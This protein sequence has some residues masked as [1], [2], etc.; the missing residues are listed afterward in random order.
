MSTNLK[1]PG[2]EL[3]DVI[4]TGNNTILYRAHAIA[5]QQPVVLK[6]LRAEYPTL[7]QIARLNHEYKV[8][9]RLDLEGIVRVYELISLQNRLVLVCEDFGGLS[10]K[11]WL[12]GEGSRQRR[13]AVGEFLQIG[14]QLAR[15]LESLQQQQIIHKDIKPANIIINPQTNVVKLADFSIASRLSQET[16]QLENSTQLEGTLLYMSPEQTGRMNRAVDYR[17][18]FYS[19]GVTFYELLTGQVPFQS[20]D[21][22][23]LVHCHIAKEPLPIHELNPEVPEGVAAIVTKLMAKNAEDRYQS[24]AGLLA[25]LQTCLTQWQQQGTIDP[26]IPGRLD[27]LSQLTIPPTLYGREPEQA[28]LLAAF[29]RIAGNQKSDRRHQANTSPSPPA[30]RHSPPSAASPSEL[31]LISGYAGIGKSSLVN[32]F[33]Q[34]VTQQGGYFVTGKFDQFKRHIPYAPFIQTFGALMRQLLLEREEQLEHWCDRLQQA[35]GE[36]GQVIIDVIPELELVIGE[37]PAVIHLSPT[38]AQ[39]RFN[40]V[41]RNFIQVFAQPES[42]LVIFLDDLQW[43]DSASLKL[44]YLLMTAP[45]NH[46]LLFIGAY[47]NHEM[48]PS[49]PLLPT[50]QE[51]QQAGTRVNQIELHPLSLESVTQLIAETLNEASDHILPLAQCLYQQ[52]GG[53][54]F[55]LTQLLYTLSQET[56]LT[57]DFEA[58]R[59]Q[60]NLEQVETTGMLEQDMVAL[61]EHRIQK[62]PK[63]TQNVFKFA[64]CIG[65]KFSLETLSLVCEQSSIAITNALH[66]A[67]KAELLL[68]LRRQEQDPPGEPGVLPTK[69]RAFKS[70]PTYQFGHEQIYQAAYSL[71]ADSE[72]K[73]VH[74]KVGQLLLRDRSAPE[75]E[76]NIFEIVNQL[77]AGCDLLTDPVKRAQ[78]AHLNLTA[79]RR[80]KAAMAYQAAANYLQI[81]RSLLPDTAWETTYDLT[82]GLH[83]EAVDSEFAATHFDRAEELAAIVL[84][85]AKDH[86]DKAK[87]YLVLV[88]LYGVTQQAARSIQTAFAAMEELQVAIVALPPSVPGKPARVALSLP[89]LEAIDTLPQMSNPI[90]LAAM[91]I[92]VAL[93]PVAYL[94]DF[95]VLY[96]VVL[97]EINLSLEYGHCPQSASAYV[98][99]GAILSGAIGD[100]AQGYHAGQ[101]GLKLL[102]QYNTKEIKCIVHNLIAA[103][104]NHWQEH[105]R[106]TLPRLMLA[107]E[108]ALDIGDYA[109]AGNTAMEYCHQCFWVEESLETVGCDQQKI[110]DLLL[111][112]KQDATLAYA[113]V[114][115][116]LVQNLQGQ[117]TD[118][119]QLV[120]E[121]YNELETLPI[122][123]ETSNRGALCCLYLAKTVLH[124]LLGNFG[125]AVENAALAAEH[126]QVVV[127]SMLVSGHNFYSSL[128]LLA[129]YSEVAPALQE[130]YLQQVATHQEQLRHWATHAPM[131]FQHKCDLIEAEQCRIGGQH[132]Q[133]MGLYD[134][135]I[136]GAMENGYSQEAAIANELAGAFYL[137]LDQESFARMHL[138]DAYYGY[139]RWG[140]TVKVK[141]LRDRYGDLIHTDNDKKPK[142]ASISRS[143]STTTS[144]E[145]VLDLATVMKAAEA[146]TSEIRLDSLLRKFLP[147]VLENAAAQK[148]CLLL[149][150]DDQLFI[151]AVGS[152]EAEPIAVLQSIPLESCTDLPVSL[153]NYVARTEQSLV[154]NDA[155]AEEISNA[156]PYI[157]TYQPKSVLCAPI[158]YQGEI[159]GVIYLENRLTISA[160]TPDR[161][162]LLKLLTTQ[163]AI[164]I[165]NAQLYGR[166]QDNSRQ[167][168]QSLL[169][170][171][172]TQAQLVQTEK[173]SSLGQLVAGVAHEVNNPVGFISGNLQCATQ[174]IEDLLKLVGL[175]QKHIPHPPAEIAT[176]IELIDLE[177]LV[178][179][180]PK[181]VSSMRVGTDRI[182]DIMQS[183]RNFSR[184]DGNEKRQTNIHEGIESTL[185]ILQHRLKAREN[186]PAI[187]VVKEYGDIPP[188]HCFAGQLN[189]VFMN[190]LANAIDALDESNHSKTYAEIEKNPNTII[191]STTVVSSAAAEIVSPSSVAPSNPP[192]HLVIRISDNG[193]GMTEATRQRLFEPFFTTKPEGKGTGLGL[194]ISYQIVTEAHRGS[195]VCNSAPGQ[196]A[197]FV[198]ELP[199][200]LDDP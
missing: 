15:A 73:A 118:P 186:R 16:P 172:Q 78:L 51:I 189:Q 7:E 69:R 101:L 133:A 5:Q 141:Q 80:S 128:S 44:I 81:G 63:R 129:H 196:G 105:A 86:L 18:D 157:Q 99:Y 179:D 91:E 136:Q 57:F 96:R 197:E 135:A 108:S 42:P 174:Y 52:T 65:D 147:I 3:T 156:D 114:W 102:D 27:I 49:H 173:I 167:L 149:V 142:N 138:T 30:T 190:L 82:L 110:I 160:F 122:L 181:L 95:E 39:N 2:Y 84:D 180:L 1:I 76:A 199:M 155:T 9:E 132:Q 143:H 55:F 151:E 115:R 187:Q 14:V 168:Q 130:H 111:Q 171:Q 35:L 68:P 6:I 19:L 45:D 193:L 10:L 72:A 29:K 137:A 124:Y 71:M 23:E 83:M 62:L 169:Q 166:E 90:I 182:R 37:Q 165:K 153:I 150:K 162:E 116:Q 191:I 139:L 25:D 117:A 125:E 31:L 184:T 47:R 17:S 54:P 103:N 134:C 88:H 70:K 176:E 13:L 177:F 158:L 159:T 194:S 8:T 109:W 104:I 123:E 98:W 22:L 183:L 106:E 126:T 178:E 61:V 140:A 24:G 87:I 152:N 58:G 131:N 48:P 4:H 161:L 43:V 195:L 93:N 21:P 56:I 97:T 40:R 175:Y 38:E 107:V 144:T 163:A 53:N 12:D 64:A 148:G 41:F 79:A 112:L 32:Q 20:E 28:I 113:A 127:G 188:V 198:I 119:R 94:A 92:L 60:W 50:V 170:L 59:W 164:G 11:E 185:M 154:L 100:I 33:N 75:I 67:L 145:S 121:N 46:S 74:L 34:W 66:P 146:I 192:P 120:G 85:H 36:S 26:F 77:N 89:T 200:R